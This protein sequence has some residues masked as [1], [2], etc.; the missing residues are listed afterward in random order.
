[1]EI[2]FP[3][4]EDRGLESPVHGHFGSARFFTI[5]TDDG[6]VETIANSDMNHPHG[7]CQPL[8]ALGRPVDAVAAG[9][10]GGGALHKLNDA[11]VKVYRAVE[12]TVHDNLK[13]IRSARLPEFTPAQICAGHGKDGECAHS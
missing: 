7:R 5:V 2:A 12:G 3:T 11:G 9:G 4:D 10:I 8:A 6:A 13:L 1:M